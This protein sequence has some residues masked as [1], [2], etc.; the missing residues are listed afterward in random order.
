MKILAISGGFKDGSNDAMAREA[1]MGAKEQG[2]EIEFIRLLDLDLKPC[3]GC[4]ACVGGMMRGGT[5]ECV[6]KDD[7]KWLDEKIFSADGIIIVM[8]VFEKGVP[9]VMHLIQDRL[10]GPTYDPGPCTIAMKIAKETG[11]PG[12]DPRK[13]VRKVVSFIAIG[14]SDWVTL[15]STALNLT[16]MARAWKVIDDVVFKWSKSIV[17]NDESVAKCHEI[18]VNTAK[19][20]ALGAD[21]AEYLGEPG[22]CPEC[23]SRNFYVDDD[24]KGTICVVCGLTGELKQVD[25]K[26]TFVVPED[27]FEHSH[28]R[29]S[30]KFEHMADIKRIEMELMEHKK[31]EEFKNRIEK[32]KS[33][34]QASKP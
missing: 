27:Q 17:M 16:A 33:F 31:T 15:A 19:A 14:G 2:A 1:L 29:M 21:K 3:T 18:G 34:I 11:G 13:L 10:F 28:F 25:G 8:P 32:Y 4:I 7:L 24:P 20:A 9:A 26:M 6:I 22:A 23:H 5:G 12:P 30:G